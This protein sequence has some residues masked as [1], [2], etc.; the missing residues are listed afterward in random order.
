MCECEREREKGIYV[1]VGVRLFTKRC[2]LVPIVLIRILYKSTTACLRMR[3]QRLIANMAT[4]CL[5]HISLQKNLCFNY[6][7]IWPAGKSYIHRNWSIGT[8]YHRQIYTD[9]C[10]LFPSADVPLFAPVRMSS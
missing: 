7:N 8:R 2:F 4:S 6:R 9:V 5:W 3:N 10:I 1:F